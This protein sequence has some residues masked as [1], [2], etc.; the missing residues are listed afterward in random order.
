M[1][2]DFKNLVPIELQ[3]L[4]CYATIIQ[5]YNTLTKQENICDIKDQFP[6]LLVQIEDGIKDFNEEIS[7]S[8]LLK[9][10]KEKDQISCD[11]VFKEY[12]NIKRFRYQDFSNIDLLELNN[13]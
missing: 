11:S 3:S 13:K 5:N 6:V 9:D 10:F 2:N 1:T 12:S 7:C 8:S 4:K